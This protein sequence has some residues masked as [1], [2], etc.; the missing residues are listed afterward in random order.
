MDNLLFLCF[1]VFAFWVFIIEPYTSLDHNYHI[2]V[3]LGSSR[4]LYKMLCLNFLSL[5]YYRIPFNNCFQI[6]YIKF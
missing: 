2:Y 3:F 5:D 1:L 4:E 6:Y